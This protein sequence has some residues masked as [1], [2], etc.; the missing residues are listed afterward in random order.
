MTPLRDD[1]TY[2]PLEFERKC[3]YERA[4]DLAQFADM[5]ATLI[6]MRKDDRAHNMFGAAVEEIEVL[7]M[8]FTSLA[9]A[10][11]SQK[12]SDEAAREKRMEQARK[13]AERHAA[14]KQD[15][16]GANA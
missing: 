8:H 15:G 11:K 14:R 3:I 10:I 6:Q 16:D 7:R 13:I 2:D 4:Q 9:R 12:E 5:V 1:A